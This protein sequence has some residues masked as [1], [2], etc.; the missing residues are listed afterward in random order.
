MKVGHIFGKVEG[1][2]VGW[3]G[4]LGWLVTMKKQSNQVDLLNQVERPEEVFFAKFDEKKVEIFLAA[5]QRIRFF[6]QK[7]LL[8]VEKRVWSQS[9]ERGFLGP[10]EGPYLRL[11]AGSST[12]VDRV[13][14]R[15][16]MMFGLAVD[17]CADAWSQSNQG[18]G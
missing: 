3:S 15:Q 18:F 14:A 7:M 9:D 17:W 12:Y 1:K 16:A 6:T 11:T 5:T 10:P 2:V 8:I 13:M 4:S